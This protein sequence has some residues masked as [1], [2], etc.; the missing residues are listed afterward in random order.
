MPSIR[1][2]F[3]D[4]DGNAW[5]S[6]GSCWKGLKLAALNKQTGL[7]LDAK[8]A[9]IAIAAN[10]PTNILEESYIRHHGEFYY[11]WESVDHCCRG[12]ASNYRILVGRSKNV[13]G[14]YLDFNS[15]PMLEGGGTLVLAS[16]DSV[17]GPGSCAIVQAGGREYL[18]HHEY[19]AENHGT[20]TLQIRALSYLADGW[21][22]VGLPIVGRGNEKAHSAGSLSGDWDVRY[23]F[24]R[25]RR[26]SLNADGL[27]T[28][29]S[30]TWHIAGNE[31]RF[32]PSQNSS[33]KPASFVVSEDLDSFVGRS[34]KGQQVTAV[35]VVAGQSH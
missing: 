30:Y 18:I 29:G 27:V 34:A 9:P 33:E 14:P 6:L 31:L 23:D 24:A 10:P 35:R 25:P 2:A 7:L 3:E 22:V 21:P 28:P 26:V 15:R 32:E 11:L 4:A 12:I 16:Y 1:V 19:D 8:Q 5:L 13:R 20:P 17:R